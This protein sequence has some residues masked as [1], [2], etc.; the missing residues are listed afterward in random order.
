MF[1][2][3]SL[4]RND[5]SLTMTSHPTHIL[6]TNL[7]PSVAI[8]IHTSQDQSLLWEQLGQLYGHAMQ[9]APASEF[10]DVILMCPCSFSKEAKGILLEKQDKSGQVD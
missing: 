1:P 9:T 3:E 6:R 5:S 4:C 10:S 2:L 7:L 8:C